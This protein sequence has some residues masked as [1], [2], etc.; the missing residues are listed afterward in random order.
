MKF[1]KENWIGI[2][3]VVVG[4]FLIL[5]IITLKNIHFKENPNKQIDKVIYYE[6]FGQR[7]GFREGQKSQKEESQKK[8]CSLS[9]KEIDEKCKKIE[10]QACK[11]HECCIWSKQKNKPAVCR[12][13]KEQG[14]MLNDSDKLPEFEW[15]WYKGTKY[16]QKSNNYTPLPPESEEPKKPV[17]V[18]EKEAEE[19]N[20]LD[21][22]LS[23]KHSQEAR[24]QKLEDE[25][26][27]AKTEME[28]KFK[29]KWRELMAK[30]ASETNQA[31]VEENTAEALKIV[32]ANERQKE[33]E[34]E[35]Q[36]TQA[37]LTKSQNLVGDK[38]SETDKQ[39]LM[40]IETSQRELQKAAAAAQAVIKAK[41][42]QWV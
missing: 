3:L 18:A 26:K 38:S 42:A 41:T 8:L 22:V 9:P 6:K 11:L 5:T 28:I 17:D 30:L 16:P 33:A 14:L 21:R 24:K 19:R 15:W 35:A 27:R 2:S 25:E 12:A 37:E 32:A 1:L 20:I 39:S 40:D 36:K 7:E 31:R 29:N 34:K 4:L 23:L 10:E 13:G